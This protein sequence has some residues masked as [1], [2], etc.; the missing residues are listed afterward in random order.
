MPRNGSGTYSKPAGTTATANTLAESAKFNEL[1]DD[2]GSEITASLPVAGTKAMA[3]NLP[4][5]SNRITGLAVGTA[6]TDGASVQQVQE[7]IVGWADSSG[8]DTITATYSPAITAYTDGMTLGFRAAAA[9][10]SSAPTFNANSVGAKVIYK[11]AGS[12]LVAGDIAGDHHDCVIV[13]NTALN[14]AAGGWLLLNPQSAQEVNIVGQTALTAVATGDSLLIYDL[15]ATANKSITV[16]DFFDITNGWTE[17]TTPDAAADYVTTWDA[18]ASAA[19]KV[20]LKNLR[21]LEFWEYAIGDESTAVTTGTAKI[22]V[23]APKALTVTDVRASATAAGAGAITLDIN[24]SGTTILSTKLSMD[25][26]EKTSTTAA[27]P[28]VIS[29]TAIANDAEITIDV[30]AVTGTWAG[31]KVRIYGYPA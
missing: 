28:A 10:T 1:M 22:T 7:R 9:N 8:T 12:A 29:D 19:K 18:S 13:Y 2:I 11:A 31:V 24:E 5:G 15:S 27:T 23:R 17:D 20:L 4:M 14:A 21:P 16:T 26:S 3:A 30:D 6:L 25:A